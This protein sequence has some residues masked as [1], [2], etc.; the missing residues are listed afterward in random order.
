MAIICREH[1]LLFIMVPGTGCSA[2]ANALVR[3]VAGQWLPESDLVVG[4]RKV[5]NRKHNSIDDLLRFELITPGELH[6]HLTFATIRN[7]FDSLVTQYERLT[8]EWME[9]YITERWIPYMSGEPPELVAQLMQRK[10]DDIAEAR[11]LGFEGWLRRL[12]QTRTLLARA[13]AWAKGVRRRRRVGRR[14]YLPY[15]MIDGVRELIR[16]ERLEDDLNRL[17]RQAGVNRVVEVPRMNVTPGKR[18]YTEYYSERSRRLV[19]ARLGKELQ[20]F[21]Y[22]FGM[23]YEGASTAP[24]T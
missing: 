14:I 19:E 24:K 23:E 1:R 13:S 16:Y 3:Q 6:N 9:R 18:P 11:R 22:R 17:L 4:T 21:G 2:V 8:G 15:P 5:L 20:R 7:P 12:L 10:R